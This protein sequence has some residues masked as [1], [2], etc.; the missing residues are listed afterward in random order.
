MNDVRRIWITWTRWEFW[1]WWLFNIP[2]AMIIAFYVVRARSIFF[3]AKVNPA[4][5]FGGFLGESKY[6]ILQRLPA[7]SRP[8]SVFF[9]SRKKPDPHDLSDIL[10]QARI[11]FPVVVKP[12]I[13]ERGFLVAVCAKM[14]DL[15]RHMI[16]YNDA[17]FIIQPFIDYADE[18]SVMYHRRP[19]EKNGTITSLC[20]KGF[21]QVTG[22]G[23]RSIPQLMA[24]NIRFAQQRDR[25]ISEHPDWMHTIPAKG[26]TVLLEPIGNHCRGTTF[27]NANHLISPALTAAFDRISLETD[28]LYY[29][30]FDL[31]CNSLD[32]LSRCE[33]FSILEYNGVTAEPAHI[34]HPGR[35]L[36]KAWRD[37]A[38]HWAILYRL[39]QMPPL[40]SLPV[41]GLKD[42]QKFYRQWKS[43][44]K[45][46]A[47][48]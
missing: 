11:D 8:T 41:P 19:D 7:W 42:A 44:K 28:G 1:P 4:I 16:R 33:Q 34:Y 20:R 22:D 9:A 31:K 29:G 18:Y 48:V 15:I 32:S 25:L 12:D 26:E 3:F 17:D 45:I 40:A 36:W 37:I 13:G 6:D 14:D 27:F 21:L 46:N 5:P 30:R 24:N 23:E 10:S 47:I 2:V 38:R 35:S 43:S 39:S